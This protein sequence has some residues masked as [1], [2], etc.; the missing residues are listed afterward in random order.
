[1]VY[2]YGYMHLV[3]LE[4]LAFRN[5][6]FRFKFKYI[7]YRKWHSIFTSTGGRVV[8][9]SPVLIRQSPTNYI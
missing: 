9:H 4:S 7:C 1:M 8:K 2:A 5:L 6:S 3:S